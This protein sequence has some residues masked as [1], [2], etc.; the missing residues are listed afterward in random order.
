[1][2]LS[3]FFRLQKELGIQEP[4]KN[5]AMRIYSEISVIYSKGPYPMKKKDYCLK[6]ILELHDDYRAVIKKMKITILT[7]LTK[8][9]LNSK[10]SLILYVTCQQRTSMK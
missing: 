1:M 6:M 9:F 7:I 8:K 10:Q 4:K 2:C 5:I 3:T